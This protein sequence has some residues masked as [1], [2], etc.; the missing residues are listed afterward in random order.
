MSIQNTPI[1]A[2][3]LSFNLLNIN[4][5]QFLLNGRPSK[6]DQKFAR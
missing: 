3:Y 5:A 2:D 6:S 4:G 1:L